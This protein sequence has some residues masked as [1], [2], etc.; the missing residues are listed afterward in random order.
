MALKLNE[1]IKE[2]PC[3]AEAKPLLCAV[4]RESC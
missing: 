4:Q 2:I 3:S 1:I